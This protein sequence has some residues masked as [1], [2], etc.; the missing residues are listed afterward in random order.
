MF[1]HLHVHSHYS[2]LESIIKIPLL[3][4]VL[5]TQWMNTVGITDLNGLYGALEFYE[6]AKKSDIKPII[7]VQLPRQI[8][9]NW[10]HVSKQN[11]PMYTIGLLARDYQGLQSLIKIVSLAQKQQKNGI[12]L[13]SLEILQQFHQG[14]IC[15]LWWVDSMLEAV[16]SGQY[17]QDH[18]HQ[19]VE[20]LIQLVGTEHVVVQ[21]VAQAINQSPRLKPLHE[22]S[23]AVAQQYGLALYAST[24]V[25]YLQPSDQEAYQIS[26]AIKDGLKRTDPQRRKPEFD[27][28][29]LSEQQVRTNLSSYGY[30]T[31]LIDQL[32]DATSMI[33][34]QCHVV[35]PA[36]QVFFPSYHS[37]DDIKQIYQ[38]YRDWLII[39]EDAL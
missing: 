34:D 2:F 11:V 33:A 19:T 6:Y 23:I 37:P 4:E 7:G 3:L 14:I 9:Q 24:S 8:P 30:D 27:G 15:C 39:N 13:L 16:I 32:I 35:I 5:S 10:F 36:G 29:L 31:A 38:T 22:F 28:S 1:T 17:A 18:F 26:L 21:L 12:P 25:R 20:W